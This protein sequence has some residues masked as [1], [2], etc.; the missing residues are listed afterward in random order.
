MEQ[1]LSSDKVNCIMQ[2]KNGFMWFGTDY[3]LN[4]Y[5][6]YS[7]KVFLNNN[8]NYSLTENNIKCIS[9]DAIGNIWIGTA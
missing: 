1:G 2:D 4:R 6:G 8:Y 3:G 9:Q 5:D 7:F